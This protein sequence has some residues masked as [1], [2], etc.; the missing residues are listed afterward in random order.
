MNEAKQ[1]LIYS[2]IITT[3]TYSIFNYNF[4]INFIFFI[5]FLPLRFPLPEVDS[6][7]LNKNKAGTEIFPAT[8]DGK[9]AVTL[10]TPEEKYVFR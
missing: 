5:V 8:A 3:T 2:D 10:S 6:S 1:T 9:K 4:S 7:E